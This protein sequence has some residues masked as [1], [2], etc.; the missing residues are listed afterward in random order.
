MLSCSY[1]D[2]FCFSVFIE[3]GPRGGFK[4]YRIEETVINSKRRYTYDEVLKII[5]TGLG[6][7]AYLI[8]DLHRIS[9]ILRSNRFS[10]GGINFETSEVRFKFDEDNN[11]VEVKLKQGNHATQLV[12]ECMLAA[13]R[14]VA[15]HFRELSKK[16]GLTNLIPSIYRIHENPDKKLISE[17]I[18]FIN[19]LGK[20]F[21]KKDIS[22]KMMNQIIEY[23]H[24]KPEQNLVNTVLIRS[25]PKA[26]Y[27]G[28]NY[29][30][31]GLGFADYTHFTSPIRR[32]CDLIVHRFIKEYSE[33][34]PETVRLNYLKV[35]V[36]SVSKHISDTERKAMDAERASTKLTHALL[37][38]KR[39]G[40]EFNG[41]ITG[42]VS[43]G[44]FV[45]V[46]DIFAEGLVRIR[47]VKGEYFIFDEKKYRFVGK[48]SNK[49]LKIGGRVK[50]F[51][52]KVNLEK[53]LIDFGFIS[54]IEDEDEN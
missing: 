35:F 41:T 47:D 27:A 44:I 5:N 21:P 33:I 24:G 43:Y 6:D 11:P 36:N 52:E 46:D 12:E 51:L 23:Y 17:A 8:K 9:R 39:V 18:E 37:M 31:F 28:K 49:E 42:I 40:E 45:M 10:H 3:L 19:S 38:E 22:S 50:V 54:I 32:Y 25:M 13:N 48:S 29:G 2:R 30:H 15:S 14:V 26:Y 20:A 1:E 16:Y 34:Q 53:R 7:N 4:D